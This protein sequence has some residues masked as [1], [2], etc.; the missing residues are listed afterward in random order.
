[1]RR[2]FL[3]FAN[4][5]LL[6]LLPAAYAQIG[7]VPDAAQVGTMART[8]ALNENLKDSTQVADGAPKTN[9]AKKAENETRKRWVFTGVGAVTVIIIAVSLRK[10]RKAVNKAN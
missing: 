4:S 8:E 1:M 9:D 10:R 6:M 2:Y 5:A 7:T 3:L